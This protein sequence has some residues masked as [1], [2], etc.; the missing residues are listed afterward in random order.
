[1]EV[2]LQI[3]F[4]NMNTA[5]SSIVRKWIQQEVSKLETFCRR[6]MGC[7]VAVEMPHH[8]HRRGGSYHVRIDLTLPGAELVI[9]R[10]PNLKY[11]AWQDG[12]PQARKR[13]ELDGPHKNLRKA[14]DDAF[15][16]AARRLQAF[17]K[18]RAGY[19][20]K[21]QAAPTARVT[22][23]ATKEGYGFLA[24]EDGR[25]VYFHRDSVLNHSF[26][27]LK[28]GSTVVFAEEPGEKGPQAS[29]VRIVRKRRP[30]GVAVP[31]IATVS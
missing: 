13:L 4:R 8:H 5:S 24:T 20:K 31:A 30:T 21:H 12:E 19:V 26:S 6:I 7:R 10:Q 11:R 29:T 22:R 27:R 9:K 2:P 1:M 17:V 28:V 3:T 16:A 18:R 14:I 23:L 25:E 15:R